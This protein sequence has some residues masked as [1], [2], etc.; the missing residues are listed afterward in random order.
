VRGEREGVGDSKRGRG[1][2][3]K[4][5]P[6]SKRL[7]LFP[8]IFPNCPISFPALS[9]LSNPTPLIGFKGSTFLGF[10]PDRELLPFYY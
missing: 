7:S 1:G 5:S 3:L 2:E 10:F 9:H 4:L 6:N 8:S